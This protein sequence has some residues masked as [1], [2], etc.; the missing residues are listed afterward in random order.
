MALPAGSFGMYEEPER[1]WLAPLLVGVALGAAIG[2]LFMLV[3]RPR[4]PAALP[5]QHPTF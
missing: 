4:A 3:R 5:P 1:G 2:A